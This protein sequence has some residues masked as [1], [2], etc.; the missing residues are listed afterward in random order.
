MARTAR[1]V[2]RRGMSW[3]VE[4]IGSDPWRSFSGWTPGGIGSSAHA[5]RNLAANWPGFGNGAPPRDSEPGRRAPIVEADPKPS[6]DVAG[7]N[8]RVRA[9]ARAG[10]RGGRKAA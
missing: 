5:A 9:G 4:E 7:H 6:D 2:R 1:P 3:T 8:R 10:R